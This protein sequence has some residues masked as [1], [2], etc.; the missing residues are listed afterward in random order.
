L[1][2]PPSIWRIE[3]WHPLVVHFPIVLLLVG[4]FFRIGV[5]GL[6]E[7]WKPKFLTAARIL[8]LMGVLGAW[9]AI[10]TGSEA[11]Y[12]V[13]R[14]LC[15]PT[16]ADSHEYFAY[17]TGVLFSAGIVLDAL[18][19]CRFRPSSLAH[20]LTTSIVL[21]FLAGSLTLIYTGHQGMKLVY[22][23]S[24]GVYQPTDQCSAFYEQ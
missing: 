23:Q 21:C 20:L 22:Q 16:V 7:S 17:W 5:I 10:W 19:W 4:A 14:T 12:E 24:A 11:Y 2:A 18:E 6:P 13:V 9:A 3:L 8:L 15:D 1:Q